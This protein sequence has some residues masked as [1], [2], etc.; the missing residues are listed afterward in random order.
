[1][2]IRYTG[3]IIKRRHKPENRGFG[4]ISCPRFP[5]EKFF[6]RHLSFFDPIPDRIPLKETK[7]EFEIGEGNGENRDAINIR[8]IEDNNSSTQ[9]IN[10]TTKHILF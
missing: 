1:M 4:F 10:E 2:T 3:E 9:K 5:G 6:F 7:V 8:I